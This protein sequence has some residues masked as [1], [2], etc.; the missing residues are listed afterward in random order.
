MSYL[1]RKWLHDLAIISGRKIVQTLRIWILIKCEMLK[2]EYSIQA[3]SSPKESFHSM[4]NLSEIILEKGIEIGRT[5]GRIEGRTDGWKEKTR[6][7]VSL[8]SRVCCPSMMQ[9]KIWR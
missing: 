1:L 7:F 5:E 2:R 6:H 3:T 9:Q 4:F 8:C